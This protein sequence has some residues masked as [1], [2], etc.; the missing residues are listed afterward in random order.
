MTVDPG[1]ALTPPATDEK[2]W[3]DE[4]CAECGLS[5]KACDEMRRQFRGTQEKRS[6]V[7]TYIDDNG[8]F[9]SGKCPAGEL[10]LSLEDPRAQD[11]LWE[12]AQRLRK[13]DEERAVAV[14]TCLQAEGYNVPKSQVWYFGCIEQ[15]G[16]YLWR[17]PRE[18]AGSVDATRWTRTG[19]DSGFAP[20][21][22]DEQGRALRHY[23]HGHTIVSFWDR[24]VDKRGA[25]N[26]SFIMR[27]DHS[28]ATVVAAARVAY[29][30]VWA[31]FPF[32]V[33]EVR[34]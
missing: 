14:E 9:K 19:I 21:D 32:E 12:Y 4:L 15:S 1:H 25:C 28:F 27:G 7:N 13:V 30:Q 10:Q 18:K 34:P 26:S 33:I 23:V 22:S 31:R 29:P 20:P 6:D 2:V 17:T 24:S 11:L 16:H 5:K 8:K 3:G